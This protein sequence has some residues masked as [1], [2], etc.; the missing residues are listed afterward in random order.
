M[1]MELVKGQE[2]FDAI[3]ELEKYT[4]NNARSLFLQIL[5]AVFFLH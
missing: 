4:E 5:Q 2:I 1:V 3:A